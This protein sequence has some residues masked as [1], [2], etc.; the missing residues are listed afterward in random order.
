MS[1]RRRAS[2]S[3]GGS[4]PT[5]ATKPIEPEPEEGEPVEHS[6]PGAR[7]P[8]VPDAAREPSAAPSP[9]LEA[10]AEL[11]VQRGIEVPKGL[12]EA[13]PAAYAAQ[14]AGAVAMLARLNDTDL[15]ERAAKVA[16]WQARQTLRA[17]QVWDSSPLI[18]ELRRRGLDEPPRPARPAGVAFS[19]KRPLAEWSDEELQDAAREWARIGQ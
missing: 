10:L 16:G 15:A 8:V 5:P 1:E 14:G 18:G 7:Q 17:Q 13:P 6:A 12:G 4:R 3:F 19:L 2:S 9:F 11:L